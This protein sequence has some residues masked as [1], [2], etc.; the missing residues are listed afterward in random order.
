MSLAFGECLART[1][2]CV[3]ALDLFDGLL[4]KATA[5]LEMPSLLLGRAASYACMDSLPR[6]LA[7]YGNVGTKYPKSVYSAEAYYRIGIIYQERLDSLKLAADA[8]ARVGNEYANSEFASV[9]LERSGSIKRLL[10]LQKSAG[11]GEGAEQAAEKRFMA[12][13]IQL[14]KLDDVTMALAGYTAVLDSFP[15]TPVAPK[16]A[17][18]I[19]WISQNKLGEKEA[20]VARY[21][22][23]VERY[24]RSYQAKGALYQLEIAGADSLR[25]YLQA[26]RDSAL[27]DTTAASRPAPVAPAAPVLPDTLTPAKRGGAG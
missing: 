23:L 19:A 24:P 20:A 18:A 17:Y 2:E 11:A 26:Y 4:A 7:E 16:A 22:A 13:E 5:T 1:G 12:A 6:A 21:R 15:E 8:F 10:D 25:A 3:E 27:A 9:S 14:T